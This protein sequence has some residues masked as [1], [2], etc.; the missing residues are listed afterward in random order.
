M[1]Y[2]ESSRVLDAFSHYHLSNGTYLQLSLLIAYLQ[3]LLG[4]DPDCR[5]YRSSA[6]IRD[7]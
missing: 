5:N 7:H 6:V 1:E 3:T 4:L 2:L